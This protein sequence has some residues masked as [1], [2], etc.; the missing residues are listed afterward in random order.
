MTLYQF[1][2]QYLRQKNQ[3]ALLEALVVMVGALFVALLL[4]QVL[5]RFVYV[6]Q[7]LTTEPLV[8]QAIPVVALAL[9]VL[10]LVATLIGNFLRETKLRKLEKLVIEQASASEPAIDESE[11]KELEK[12]VDSALSKHSVTSVSKPKTSSTKTS[13]TATK[14]KATTKVRKTK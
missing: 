9:G 11:L 5:V 3:Q 8:F 14:K 7:Q 6:S 2:I 4:P 12:L 1:Q 10:Q 13:K